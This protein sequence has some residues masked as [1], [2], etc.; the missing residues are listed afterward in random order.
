MLFIIN[1]YCKF[2]NN[3]DWNVIYLM[4]DSHDSFL[5][6]HISSSSIRQSFF[7]KQL[8]ELESEEHRKPISSR[9]NILPANPD[10]GQ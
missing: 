3:I 4:P 1:K 8:T 2:S 7:Y 5:F 10:H 9:L 6:F